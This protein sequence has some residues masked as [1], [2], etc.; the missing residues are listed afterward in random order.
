LGGAGLGTGG[1]W[2]GAGPLIG[3][4][5]AGRRG[6][7]TPIGCGAPGIAPGIPGIGIPGIGIPGIGIPGVG[8]PG[9]GM[10]GIG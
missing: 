9:V 2:P 1:T 5:A 7:G 8:I 10:P 4:G 6:W 3:A